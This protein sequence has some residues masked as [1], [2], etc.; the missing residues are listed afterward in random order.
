MVIFRVYVNLAEGILS[1]IALVR[2]RCWKERNKEEH[3]CTIVARNASSIT[4]FTLFAPKEMK[5]LKTHCLF[6]FHEHSAIL[7]PQ[8]S[9]H[10]QERKPGISGS[11]CTRE[12]K[13]IRMKHTVIDS[14][15]ECDMVWQHED[16]KWWLTARL[17]RPLRGHE[18]NQNPVAMH[19]TVHLW[20]RSLFTYTSDDIFWGLRYNWAVRRSEAVLTSEKEASKSV[21][22]CSPVFGL[23]LFEDLCS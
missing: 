2:I 11:N 22:R 23:K 7:W 9:L 10:L 20:C 4:S 15:S 8:V 14:N 21:V 13:H 1:W 16:K 18:L 6:Y 17:Q 3:A 5:G 19:R 12:L